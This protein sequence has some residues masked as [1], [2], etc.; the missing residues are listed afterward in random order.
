[1]YVPTTRPSGEHAPSQ[2]SV[3][4]NFIEKGAGCASATNESLGPTHVNLVGVE[5]TGAEASRLSVDRRVARGRRATRARSPIRR[6]ARTRRVTFS[7]AKI[8]VIGSSPSASTAACASTP[9]S[10]ITRVP[11]I[12]KPP[13]IPSTGVPLPRVARRMASARPRSRSHARS[14][15]VDLVPGMMIRSGWPSSFGSATKRIETP[16]SHAS[17]WNSSRFATRGRRI[18]AMSMSVSSLALR[19]SES[20]STASSAGRRD[21]SR[22]GKHAERRNA[23]ALEQRVE[24]RDRA[25]TDRRETC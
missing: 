7:G 4:S 19:P 3:D 10:S 2:L 25:A 24:A 14:A 21:R 17:G 12:W 23:G 5:G 8:V 20:H 9:L 22:Y 15:T 13:Q 18:T 16:G 11:S 1:M 6:G